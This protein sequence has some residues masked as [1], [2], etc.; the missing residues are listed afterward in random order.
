MSR[1][2]LHR[3]SPCAETVISRFDY[4]SLAAGDGV[5]QLDDTSSQGWSQKL[6]SYPRFYRLI[7]RN[8]HLNLAGRPGPYRHEL[9]TIHSYMLGLGLGFVECHA[10]LLRKPE[11]VLT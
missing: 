5:V 7:G 2:F 3:L 1:A 11:M 9:G 6:G 4:S 10:A 8:A